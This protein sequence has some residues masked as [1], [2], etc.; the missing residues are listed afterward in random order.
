MPS[1]TAANATSTN[2]ARLSV[3]A[4][5]QEGPEARQPHAGQATASEAMAAPQR[6]QVADG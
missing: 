6:G 5:T 4:F 2:S 3:I 1:I